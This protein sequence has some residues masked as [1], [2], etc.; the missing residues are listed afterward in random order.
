MQPA[1]SIVPETP[2][3]C[4]F[5]SEVMYRVGLLPALSRTFYTDLRK[6]S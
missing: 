4:L 3:T 5:I 2:I 1:M 6:S